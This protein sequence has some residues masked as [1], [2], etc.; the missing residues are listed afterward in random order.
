[1]KE[2]LLI[3][4]MVLIVIMG[5]ELRDTNMLA[6]S[7]RESAYRSLSMAESCADR[8]ELIT[9]VCVGDEGQHA[10]DNSLEDEGGEF[11]ILI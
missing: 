2:F 4:V 11:P 9:Q 7:Y 1:M 8:M 3:M 10:E 6:E 5:L